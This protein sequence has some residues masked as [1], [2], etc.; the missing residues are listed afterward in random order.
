M[1]QNTAVD[2][3]PPALLRYRAEAQRRRAAAFAAPRD[4]VSG[5]TLMPITAASYSRLCAT[6]NAFAYDRV[7]GA[8]DV[9][10]FIW[11]HWPYFTTDPR[12]QSESRTEC[13]RAIAKTLR[14]PLLTLWRIGKNRRERR[15]RI[16]ALR[17][18]KADK[19]ISEIREVWRETFADAPPRGSG[20]YI[21]STLEAQFVHLFG[22]ELNWAPEYTSHYPL[23]QAYQLLRVIKASRSA[24]T[25][26]EQDTQ[27]DAIIAAV[28]LAEAN[29]SPANTA[30]AAA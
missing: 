26:I 18:A 20:V 30:S 25:Y 28:L 1:T 23:R 15:A 4:I 21:G 17:V 11:F 5:I 24:G 27:E 9:R 6:G 22:R 13:E 7:P 16:K 29:C 14:L 3:A 12:R 10:N 8:I 2:F 19:L